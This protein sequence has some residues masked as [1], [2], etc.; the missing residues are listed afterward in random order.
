MSR[1][2][3][4]SDRG[5]RNSAVHREVDGRHARWFL[6]VVIGVA[7]AL[8]PLAVYLLQT[9]SYVQTSYAIE[10]LRG[11]EARLTNAEHRLAIERAVIESLP[12]VEKRAGGELGLEHAQASHVI[13][14]SPGE[15]GRPP[16]T[17][18]PS[19]RPPSR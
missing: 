18:S 14:V 9:M 3:T 11:Q 2:A 15:L 6:K 4:E 5:W 16:Q 8:V 17:E 12:V 7:I 19:P 1:P 10:D 13:V